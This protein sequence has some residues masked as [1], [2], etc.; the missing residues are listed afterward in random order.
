MEGELETTASN[1][2]PTKVGPVL[3]EQGEKPT[4]I[5]IKLPEQT[6]LG[7]LPGESPEDEEVE[8]LG[9]SS[10]VDTECTPSS[11]STHESDQGGH[12]VVH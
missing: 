12:L 6:Q 5:R 1:P 10:T 11:A 2:D 4:T 8:R 3:V 9:V 7:L